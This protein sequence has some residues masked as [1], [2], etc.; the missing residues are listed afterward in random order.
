MDNASINNSMLAHMEHYYKEHYPD[1]GFSVS[2]NQIE[3]M[4]HVLNLAVQQILKQFKQ[5]VDKETYEEVSDSSDRKVSAVSRLSFLCRTIRLSP[6]LRK[7]MKSV[8]EE[9]DVRNLVP[10]ID[11]TTRWNYIHDLLV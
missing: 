2:W 6:K 1:A 5:P 3:C 7:I 11:V 4:V 9:R 10:I 8:C